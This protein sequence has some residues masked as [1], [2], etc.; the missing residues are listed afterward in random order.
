MA[1]VE[2]AT[3]SLVFNVCIESLHSTDRFLLA[4]SRNDLLCGRYHADYTR[5]KKEIHAARAQLAV[6]TSS[7]SGLVGVFRPEP[8]YPKLQSRSIR[9]RRDRRG[10]WISTRLAEAQRRASPDQR[11]TQVLDWLIAETKARNRQVAAPS[12][13]RDEEPAFGFRLHS[14]RPYEARYPVPRC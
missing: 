6:T 8:G 3:D 10:N 2:S 9:S 11:W 1:N 12:T 14:A 7:A 5:A 13:G 4:G